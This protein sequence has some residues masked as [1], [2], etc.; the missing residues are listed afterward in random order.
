MIIRIILGILLGGGAGFLINIVYR[1]ITA[2]SATVC[3]IWCNPYISI[4][5]GV[6]LGLLFVLGRR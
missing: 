3:P 2:G 1:K 4:F 5:F 6:L